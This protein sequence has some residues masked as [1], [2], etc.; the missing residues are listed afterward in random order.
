MKEPDQKLPTKGDTNTKSDV[1]AADAPN[2]AAT[3]W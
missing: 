2:F 3:A 1:H